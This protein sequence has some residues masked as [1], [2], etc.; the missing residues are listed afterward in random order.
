MCD[1]VHCVL[2]M[3]LHIEE[4]ESSRR[5]TID[6]RRVVVVVVVA[7]MMLPPFFIRVEVGRV[8][9]LFYVPSGWHESLFRVRMHRNCLV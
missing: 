6:H 8:D 3:V 7:M 1:H 5:T 9:Y 4:S 2:Y